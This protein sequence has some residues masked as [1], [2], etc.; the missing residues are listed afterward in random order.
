[1]EHNPSAAHRW[2]FCRLGGF[3]QVCLERAEDLRHLVELDQ[4]LWAGLSCPVNGLEFDSSTLAM[5][6]RDSD[7][8]VRV[9]EVLAAVIRTCS[10]LNS[11]DSVMP[12]SNIKVVKPMHSN[13]DLYRLLYNF[14]T[15]RDFY[16]QDS[17]AVFQSGTLL[18]E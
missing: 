11:L 6:N 10:V 9:Q 3:N 2:R 18:S 17:K 7:G 1:M 4:K 16:A 14:V 12:G 13:R 5:L 8:R 15:F